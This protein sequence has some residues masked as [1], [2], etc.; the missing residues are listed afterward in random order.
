MSMAH[1]IELRSPLLDFRLLEFVAGLPSQMRIAGGVTKVLLRKY[2]KGLLPEESFRKP[3]QGFGIPKDAWFREELASYSREV[4]LDGGSLS[5]E[6]F[7]R[8]TLQGIFDEHR[9]GKRDYSEWIWCLVVLELWHRQFGRQI[10]V[11]A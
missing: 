3:K 9:K 10:P 7:R 8:D 2:L 11:P 6:F 1:S 5:R 4:V